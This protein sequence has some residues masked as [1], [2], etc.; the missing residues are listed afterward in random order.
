[1]NTVCLDATYWET[2]ASGIVHSCGTDVNH[3]VQIVGVD[4]SEKYWKVRNTWGTEWG[5]DGYIRIALGSN[6]CA[7]ATDPT[8][9]KVSKALDPTSYN[10]E[11]VV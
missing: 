10:F 11:P 2:Y 5:E 8:Y 4:T 1:M 6:T 7:I 3:C 9:S